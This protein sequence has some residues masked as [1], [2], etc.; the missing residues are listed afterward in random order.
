MRTVIP[1]K[2]HERVRA[3]ILPTNDGKART[4]SEQTDFGGHPLDKAFEVLSRAGIVNDCVALGR[5]A[6]SGDTFF[7]GAKVLKLCY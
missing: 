1:G 3:D 5:R 6:I 7:C 2:H 4:R